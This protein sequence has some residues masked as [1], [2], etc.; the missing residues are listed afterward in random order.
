M[1]TRH[2]KRG[3]SHKR[4]LKR[5]LRKKTSS[6][7]KLIPYFT[8]VQQTT[9][10]NLLKKELSE[11]LKVEKKIKTKSITAFNVR[12]FK[13][14]KSY[15]V[16][17][18]N[19]Q[20]LNKLKEAISSLFSSKTS[21]FND[22]YAKAKETKAFKQL[23]IKPD[24][25]RTLC[26]NQ[27]NIYVFP[28]SNDAI[29]AVNREYVDYNEDGCIENETFLNPRKGS[30]EPKCVNK[31][32]LEKIQKE[33]KEEKEKKD[34]KHIETSR[35][36]MI[37]RELMGLCNQ[38]F[39]Q[40]LKELEIREHIT[41]VSDLSIYDK[42]FLHDILSA[43][44]NIY[45]DVIDIIKRV[46][47]RELNGYYKA[48]SKFQDLEKLQLTYALSQTLPQLPWSTHIQEELYKMEHTKLQQLMKSVKV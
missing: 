18:A 23:E 9:F 7:Q 17:N 45:D 15:A 4:T 44:D 16:N 36:K 47:K 29:D 34:K 22:W 31:Q 39:I 20:K 43:H 2:K 40:E 8:E 1:K 26:L 27:V 12:F 37:S 33:M 46:Q 10:E 35:A 42:H 38:S 19:I 5:S 28:W 41:I 14:W 13:K 48:N 25:V 11:L 24:T 3:G 21:V 32:Q 30:Q 6:S